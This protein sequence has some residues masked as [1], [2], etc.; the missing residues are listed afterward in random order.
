MSRARAR[1]V[2]FSEELLEELSDHMLAFLSVPTRV[3]FSLD[4]SGMWARKHLGKEEPLGSFQERGTHDRQIRL[5]GHWTLGVTQLLA[6]LAHEHAHNYLAFHG[7]DYPDAAKRETLTDVA[8]AYLGLGG[9]LLSGYAPF[10]WFGDGF[11][12]VEDGGRG[13]L[14]HTVTIGY[15]RPAELRFAIIRSAELRAIPDL[16]SALPLHWR[17]LASGRRRRIVRQR[18]GR[19]QM[20][21][22]QH[23][24]ARADCVSIEALLA[25][26]ANRGVSVSVEDG[27]TMVDIANRV[28]ALVDRIDRGS[29][30]LR[31]ALKRGVDSHSLDTLQTSIGQVSAVLS[32]WTATLRKYR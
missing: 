9:L 2:S 3:A 14:R 13:Y 30:D 5:H 24:A 8:A 20:L 16:L 25:Q 29:V 21:L 23:E 10:C 17:L 18:D 19:V 26:V 4:V 6:V 27:R 1:E 28:G 12:D 31:A 7:I 15:L 22:A 32:H 11:G